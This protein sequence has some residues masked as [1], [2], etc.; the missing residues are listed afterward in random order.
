MVYI[1]NEGALY[2]GPARGLPREVWS[3]AEKRFV[4]YTGTQEKPIEWG[5]VISEE[6]ASELMKDQSR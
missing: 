5:N 2:R 3:H 1:E 4:P 6:E